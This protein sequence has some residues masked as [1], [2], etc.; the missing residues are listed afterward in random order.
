MAVGDFWQ[1]LPEF[2]VLT[3]IAEDLH[4]DLRL[5]GSLARSLLEVGYRSA[6]EA[7]GSMFDFV[8]PFSD[9]DLVVPSTHDAHQVGSLIAAHLPQSRFFHWEI[10]T[11]EDV[12]RYTEWAYIRLVGQPE[13]AF[14][15]A[16]GKRRKNQTRADPVAVRCRYASGHLAVD[17]DMAVLES[18][19]KRTLR[20]NRITRGKRPWTIRWRRSW[21]YFTSPAAI[22]GYW[23]IPTSVGS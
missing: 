23:S 13:I 20:S 22:H 14:L 10:Q 9:I 5:R 18:I 4:L 17:V 19:K 15:D 2:Q 11:E 21:I 1:A 16:D 6:G 7:P 12:K 3:Q 8:Q